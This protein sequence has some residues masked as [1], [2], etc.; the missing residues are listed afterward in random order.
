[1]FRYTCNKDNSTHLAEVGALLGDGEEAFLVGAAEQ[2]H[3]TSALHVLNSK[4]QK[5][6]TTQR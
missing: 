3:Q 6:I 1:M 5:M 2:A 4:K